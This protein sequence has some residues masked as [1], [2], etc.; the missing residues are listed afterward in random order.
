MSLF[1]SQDQ[2]LT[3]SVPLIPGGIDRPLTIGS[4]TSS[5]SPLIPAPSLTLEKPFHYKY[6]TEFRVEQCTLFLQHKCSQHR[7]FTCFFWH[8]QN[9]RRRRPIRRKDGHFNHSA[10]NYCNLYD[11]NTGVCPQGDECTFLH[12]T[13]GDTERRYHLRYYKTSTCVHETDARGN[14]VKN[15]VHCAFAHGTHDMRKP[16]CDVREIQNMDE[17]EAGPGLFGSLEREKGYLTDDP[18]WQNSSFVL[19]YYKTEPCPKPPKLCRQGYACPF[20]H[21]NKDKRR[22]PKPHKYRSTPCP[23]VKVNDEWGDPRHC[24]GSDQC[25]YCHT[26]T[27]QQFHVEIYKSTKCND[28]QQT[29]YC[30]RGAFCA[31]A[32]N[33]A[34]LNAHRELTSAPLSTPVSLDL[35]GQTEG[36]FVSHRSIVAPSSLPKPIGNKTSHLGIAYS[37]GSMPHGSDLKQDPLEDELALGVSPKHSGSVAS[38]LS[39]T[40]EGGT[41]PTAEDINSLEFELEGFPFSE[42]L[43]ESKVPI[44]ATSPAA[45]KFLQTFSQIPQGP[46][47]PDY[48]STSAPTHAYEVIKRQNT[49]PL[50][51]PNQSIKVQTAHESLTQAMHAMSVGNQLTNQLLDSEASSISSDRHLDSNQRLTELHQTFPPLLAGTE[52]SS[53]I[54]TPFIHLSDQSAAGIQAD[55]LSTS[56]PAHPTDHVLLDSLLE[57]KYGSQSSLNMTT[58][59]LINQSRNQLLSTAGNLITSP[60]ANSLNSIENEILRDQLKQARERINHLETNCLQYQQ[61]VEYMKR[62]MDVIE[63]SLV[64]QSQSAEVTGFPSGSNELEHPNPWR[65]DIS[66]TTPVPSDTPTCLYCGQRSR[67]RLLQPCNHLVACLSCADRLVQESGACV[68]CKSQVLGSIAATQ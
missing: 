45:Q 15:G 47:M 59:T 22:S 16:E 26:R 62:R 19:T 66:D 39:D 10:D 28:V 37:S 34:E 13:A 68:Y 38:S 7:P 31:F 5:S 46:L 29:G 64:K 48:M 40:Q 52:G 27:E 4:P 53:S 44:L 55:L 20:F 9:Q 12:R 36:E 43:N 1:P 30:P 24:E 25:L 54:A 35:N 49:S 21:N 17:E 63:M 56:A 33:E 3:K 58:Q 42:A 11:E 60:G 67:V 14:C 51:V 6:L 57:E 65:Q 50:K 61:T 41:A 23:S 18:R 2:F 32:H 8:F